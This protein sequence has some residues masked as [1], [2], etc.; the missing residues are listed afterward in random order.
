MSEEEPMNLVVEPQGVPRRATLLWVPGATHDSAAIY[1]G[2]MEAMASKG[3]RSVALR[4]RK[5]RCTS[6]G[7]YVRQVEESLMELE[8]PVI[9]IGHSLGG[10]LVQVLLTRQRDAAKK[11]CGAVLLCAVPIMSFCQYLRFFLYLYCKFFV[12]FIMV[13]LTLNVAQLVG[14]GYCCRSSRRCRAI[15]F[16]SD[17]NS[18]TITGTRQSFEEYHEGIAKVES[19]PLL[20]GLLCY[21]ITAPSDPKESSGTTAAVLAA[22]Q[23][24]LTPLWMHQSTAAAWRTSVQPISNQGH[25]VSDEGWDSTLVPVLEQQLELFTSRDRKSVV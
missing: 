22:E 20:L 10:A 7:N 9:L 2:P 25:F 13:V 3:Y 6:L 1:R 15:G 16:A 17:P 12:P 21:A 23:D 4:L 8:E 24:V 18:V 19:I 5:S 11:A 14:G